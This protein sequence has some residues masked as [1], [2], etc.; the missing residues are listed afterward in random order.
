VCPAIISTGLSRSRPSEFERIHG[1]LSSCALKKARMR[2]PLKLWKKILGSVDM[3]VSYLI[4]LN[5]IQIVP[6]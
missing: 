3:S 5:R 1:F 4:F 6:Q 2:N